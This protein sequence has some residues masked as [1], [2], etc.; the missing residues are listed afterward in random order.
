MQGQPWTTKTGQKIRDFL[1]ESC[2]QGHLSRAARIEQLGKDSRE[3]T[4][5][6][7]QAG[8]DNWDKT[9]KTGK[10]G[11][12]NWDGKI[13]KGRQDNSARIGNKGRTAIT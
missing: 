5:G 1:R 11:Q 10:P 7:G 12:E 9:A 4:V 8:Q 13:R 3:K 6:T 2:G